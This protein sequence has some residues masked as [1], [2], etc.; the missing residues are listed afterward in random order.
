ME[1]AEGLTSLRSIQAKCR[2]FL[3]NLKLKMRSLKLALLSNP[4]LG[5]NTP[6]GTLGAGEGIRTLDILLGNQTLYH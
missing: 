4:L 2:L 6:V 3:H 5:R 1:R